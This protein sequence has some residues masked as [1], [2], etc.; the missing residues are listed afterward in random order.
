MVVSAVTASMP[1][2]V[3]KL[4]ELAADD[5]A[6]DDPAATA[7]EWAK[8]QTNDP[9]AVIV[10]QNIMLQAI[11]GV[12]A[13]ST[14]DIPDS[15][16]L[17]GIVQTSIAQSYP[18]F[19]NTSEVNKS[20]AAGIVSATLLASNQDTGF[21]F[22]HSPITATWRYFTGQEDPSAAANAVNSGV[23]YELGPF[24]FG[25]DQNYAGGIKPH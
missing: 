23:G 6:M 12:E 18:G 7:L 15:V 9:N 4:Q 5:T 10:L 3:T 20:V 17:Q 25:G 14:N 16:W 1:G 13:N 24:H 21:S 8:T 22:W 11:Q 19:A 2:L